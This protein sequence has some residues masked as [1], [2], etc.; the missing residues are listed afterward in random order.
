MVLHERMAAVSGAGMKIFGSG[1][2]NSKNLS[3]LC[4]L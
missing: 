4:S 1:E 3:V 2:K